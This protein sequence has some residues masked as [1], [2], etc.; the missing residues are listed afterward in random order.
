MDYFIICAAGDGG[1]EN[2]TKAVEDLQMM[3]GVIVQIK[4]ENELEKDRIKVI[5]I[6]AVIFVRESA[7]R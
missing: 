7:L 5:F 4:S 6:P 3:P 1:V 2:L